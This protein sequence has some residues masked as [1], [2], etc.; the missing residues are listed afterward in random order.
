LLIDGSGLK[1]RGRSFLA[2]IAFGMASFLVFVAYDYSRQY[3]GVLETLLGVLLVLSALG[4]FTVLF[5][6]AHELAEAVWSTRR[7]PFTAVRDASGFLPKVSIHVPAY[8]EPPEL[9]ISTLDALSRLDYPDFEVLVIDNNTPDE[10]TWRPV[11]A[12]CRRLGERFRFFHV[13]P[14]DGFK[15]GALNYALDRTAED[16]A[17]V[18]VIDADYEVLPGWLRGLVPHFADARIAV[19]QAPQDYRDGGGSLFKK[20]CYAEYKGFFHIGMVTRNDRDAIIQHGTMTMIRRRVLDSLRWG[21]WTITED[22]ELGLRVFASGG[23]AAYVPESCGR[24]V[25]PDRFIDYK[26]QRFRWAFGAMQIMRRHARTLFAGQG[27][28]LTRGQRYHFLAGWLPWCADGLNLFFTTGALVWTAA[29][30]IAPTQALPPDIVFA[31]PPIV[32]FIGKLTKILYVYKRHMR[33]PMPTSIGAAIAGLSLSHT[34]G[35]AVVYGLFTRSIP[36]FRTPKLTGHGGLMQALA[37]AREELYILLLL[38][39]AALGMV[40]THNLDTRDAWAWLLMLLL[41]SVSYLAAVLMSWLAVLPG[42]AEPLVPAA[43]AG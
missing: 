30:L 29:M 13:S 17:V 31:L 1:Q 12:H 24:G 38:W 10:A 42:T 25:M 11:E 15:A 6:E 2:I 26:K 16:V 28:G 4:V 36:F 22:A 20:L 34:I 23:S 5:T 37:E 9:L 7:R 19:V 14:L 27:G 21:D 43:Q 35:K 32:L 40:L 18:A 3:L 8:N 39:G 33:I 41:Q